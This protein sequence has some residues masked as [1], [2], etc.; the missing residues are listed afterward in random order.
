[1]ITDLTRLLRLQHPPGRGQRR[2]SLAGR[3]LEVDAGVC[4]EPVS[5]LEQRRGA[6]EQ[7]RGKRRI[8]EHDVER[9]R[10]ARE[11]TKRVAALNPRIS[12]LPFHE[13]LAQRLRRR[14]VALDE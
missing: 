10:L 8:E 12:S 6:G 13:E 14:R 4:R 5:L 1:M 9:P 7:R 2:Q 11:I 3:T